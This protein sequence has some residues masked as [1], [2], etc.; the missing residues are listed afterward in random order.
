M[1]STHR[2]ASP[3]E[4]Q[5]DQPRRQGPLPLGEYDWYMP[6]SQRVW[7][8]PTDV[9]ET[10]SHI[11]V[12]IEVA[13]MEES[14]FRISL[15]DRRLVV[16]GRRKDPQGK[17]IYHNM[18]IHYGEFLSEVWLGFAL[19]QTAIEATYEGGFLFVRLPKAKEHRVPIHVRTGEER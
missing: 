3:V 5:D 2:I 19:D 8:P 6:P 17:L 18:E 11:V 7:R 16:V 15:V 10:D 14:D 12:K 1:V 9:Y 13:G 4:D